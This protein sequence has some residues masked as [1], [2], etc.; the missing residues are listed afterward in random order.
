[1]DCFAQTFSTD[2]QQD[3][4]ICNEDC[5]KKTKNLKNAGFL[6][7]PIDNGAIV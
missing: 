5:V 7:L 1:M 4:Y 2:I 3:L 6:I